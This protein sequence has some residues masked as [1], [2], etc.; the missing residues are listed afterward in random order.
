MEQFEKIGTM[1]RKADVCAQC[2]GFHP[3]QEDTLPDPRDLRDMTSFK[4]T[5]DRPSKQ[6]CT[7][8]TTL[9]GEEDLGYADD[10]VSISS[11]SLS[12][13]LGEMWRYGCPKSPNWDSDIDVRSDDGG[14]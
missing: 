2:Y 9:G 11:G 7:K 12:P 6:K 1:T 8:I 4:D 3:R 5:L 13:D 14:E 10:E